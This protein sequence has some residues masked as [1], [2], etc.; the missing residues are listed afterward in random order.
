MIAIQPMQWSRLQDL[1]D[2]SYLD[3]SD[4]ACMEEARAFWLATALLH[5]SD[6]VA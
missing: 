1:H 2:V 6:Q 4:A 3:A 5:G